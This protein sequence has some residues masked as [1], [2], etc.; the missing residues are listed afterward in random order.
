MAITPRTIF[1][2]AAP[3]TVAAVSLLAFTAIG[4]VAY[5]SSQQCDSSRVEQTGIVSSTSICQNV[6]RRLGPDQSQWSERD[7]IRYATC[8]EARNNSRLTVKVA[9]RGLNHYPK[10]EP[11]YNIK[12]YHQIVLDQHNR[13]VDTLE[14]GL[15]TIRDPYTGVLENNLAWASLWAPREMP[16]DRSRELYKTALDKEPNVCAY[17]HTGLWVEYAASQRSNG[18]ELFRA[19]RNFDRLRSR[20]EP[21]LSRLE[22]AEWKTVVEIAGAA[23]MFDEIDHN[24]EGNSDAT[25]DSDQTSGDELMTRVAR[26]LESNYDQISVEAVCGEAMPLSSTHHQCV[27]H[28]GTAMEKAAAAE[29]GEETASK[30]KEGIG[31][32]GGSPCPMMR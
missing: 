1:S 4:T 10:S 19:L 12:G 16:L 32:G 14:T 18:V 5:M 24:Y 21:C 22:H 28:L 20:Y 31:G 7:W 25:S 6:E 11:L 29:K 17:V 15:K 30:V 26:H 9:S 27:D 2:S 3:A 8:F 13:A 23:V